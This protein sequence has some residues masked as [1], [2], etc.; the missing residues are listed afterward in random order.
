MQLLEKERLIGSVRSLIMEDYVKGHSADAGI[1]ILATLVTSA[2]KNNLIDNVKFADFINECTDKLQAYAESTFYKRLAFDLSTCDQDIELYI[3]LA[4]YVAVNRNELIFNGGNTSKEISNLTC[5]LIEIKDGD[6]IYDLGSGTGNLLISAYNFA[7]KDKKKIKLIGTEL[8][9]EL[10]FVSKVLLTLR[11]ADYQIITGDALRTDDHLH[12]SKAYTFPAI[13]ARY[14]EMYPEYF[15]Q[16]F[17]E[18]FNTRSNSEW[19]FVFK[20]LSNMDKNGRL[21]ALLPEGALFRSTDRDIRK[22]L[23]NN[24]LLEGIIS[25]P[26]RVID[27]TGTKMDL[28]ILG[29]SNGTFKAVDATE[30]VKPSRSIRTVKIDDEAIWK[31]YS[32]PNVRTYSY[33]EAITR[34][35]SL[36]LNAY[37]D[38]DVEGLIDNPTD[39]SDV[40]SIIVGSQYTISHFKNQFSDKPTKYQILTSGNIE[41]GLVNYS[42]LQYIEDD[43]KLDKFALQEG[44][45]VVTTKSTKVKT[46][47]VNDL[48]DRKIIVT[49]GMLIV[50]PDTDKI[51]PTY[52]KMYLDSQVGQSSLR[53]IQ[54]GSTITTI[55]VPAF[56]HLN[57]A[58]PDLEKQNALADKYNSLLSMYDALQQQMKD[59]QLQIST[60]YDDSLKGDD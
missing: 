38:I 1:G 18:L 34:D 20:A 58:C 5:R 51:N 24:N 55:S 21:V 2:A 19:Y 15:N 57:V 12:Y 48:P 45:V 28:V 10:A 54:K 41:N 37:S 43:D 9:S 8:N 23:L 14:T 25:L 6:T 35:Y 31:A 59:M 3:E 49:G 36:D 46:F 53:A 11:D 22:Y 4:D 42:S 30:M 7:K 32:D 56:K 29:S 47:V 33:E 39:L 52:L 60:L 26:A 16:Q 44:D 27:G 13:G 17:G 40:S 50:R